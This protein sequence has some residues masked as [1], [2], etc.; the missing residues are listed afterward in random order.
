[1]LLLLL[2]YI[3]Q[4]FEGKVHFVEIDIEE[5]ADFTMESSVAGTPTVQIYD[6]EVRG[7]RPW[8]LMIQ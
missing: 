5:S 1:V 2:L 3:C 8:A 7:G 6:K 4:E